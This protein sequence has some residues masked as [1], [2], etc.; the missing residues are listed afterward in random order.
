MT[1]QAFG[2]AVGFVGILLGGLAGAD[3][4]KFLNRSLYVPIEFRVC[5][6]LR[7]AVL[8]QDDEPVSLVPVR[9][10]FQFTYYPDLERQAPLLVDVRVEGL[11]ASTGESF[12]ARMAVS[13]AGLH[14]AREHKD[15]GL[16][17]ALK[18]L[19]F[20]RDVHAKETVLRLSCDRFCSRSE[21]SPSGLRVAGR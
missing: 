8:Y 19:K 13:A 14:T 12:V 18:A 16:E 17:K 21:A 9:R 11:Y 5:D 3:E 7:D 4:G 10:V 1:T 20:K 15:L 2:R 6:H